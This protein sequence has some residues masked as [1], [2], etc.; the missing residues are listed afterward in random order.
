MHLPLQNCAQ[1]KIRNSS[2]QFIVRMDD[3]HSVCL[4]ENICLV[5]PPPPVLLGWP[6]SGAQVCGEPLPGLWYLFTVSSHIFQL[7]GNF[8]FTASP[9]SKVPNTP[10]GGGRGASPSI[11]PPPH[12]SPSSSVKLSSIINPPFNDPPNRTI[13]R[14]PPVSFP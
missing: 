14:L 4:W 2:W 6:L 10:G 1:L 3:W 8:W 13:K 11:L 7:N 9:D 12:F 5:H